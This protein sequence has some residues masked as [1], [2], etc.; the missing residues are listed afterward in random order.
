MASHQLAVDVVVDSDGDPVDS[1]L[2][3]AWCSTVLQDGEA[4]ELSVCV[5]IEVGAQDVQTG[6]L[7]PLPTP[8]GKV[9]ARGLFE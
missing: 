1:T 2:P 7:E 3:G 9:T 8:V 6:G 4:G 5:D